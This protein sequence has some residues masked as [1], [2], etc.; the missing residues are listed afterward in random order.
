MSY[1]MKRVP[2]FTFVGVST[3]QSSSLQAFPGWMRVLGRPEV[4][5]EGVDFALHD[6]PARYRALIEGMKADP[7]N[8]GGLVTSHKID[9]LDASED[10]FDGLRPHAAIL[11]EVSSM[12]KRDG[13]LMGDTTDP[14]AGGRSLAGIL[15]RGYFGRTGG[16]VLCLGAG[17]AATALALY[18]AEQEREE[19]RPERMVLCDVDG[20]RLERFLE[21]SGRMPGP[22]IFEGVRVKGPEDND[23]L[24]RTLKPGSVVI[25]AT[26]LGKDR[27]GSPIT[28]AAEF[29][30]GG[31]IWELNYR[32]ERPFLHQA[33]TQ[34][35]SRG[36]K[37]ADGWSYFIHGW[38]AVI[39][40]VLDVDMDAQLMKEMAAVAEAIR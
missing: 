25:N 5:V 19:D 34:A 29:P 11:G 31:V 16:E 21:L 27:P 23:R 35:D 17:G 12:F 4:V 10:L 13:R 6:D 7:N 40:Q 39:S 22:G 28:S 33:R 24:V 2:T 30:E 20:G 9:L 18:L 8:L 38:S 3:S 37:V 32:G 15:G 1:R 26:G 14:V 36:L